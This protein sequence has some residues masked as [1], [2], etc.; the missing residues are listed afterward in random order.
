MKW[1]D[2]E[3]GEFGWLD[4]RAGIPTS[5][6]FH[7]ILTPSTRKLSSQADR[8]LYEC[9]S[10]RILGHPLD[11]AQIDGM[12]FVERGKVLEKEA[13]PAYE[14]LN[15][16]T[17]KRDGYGFCTTDDGRVGCSPD[18]VIG[19]DGLTEIKCR[20]FHIHLAHLMGSTLP[21]DM[22]QVQGAL[23]VCEREWCDVYLHNPAM[24]RVQIRVY[25]D[26]DYIRD[27]SKAVTTFAEGLERAWERYQAIDP[28]GRVEVLY[29][30]A[31]LSESEVEAV[32]VETRA[33][34]S[35]GRIEPEERD[36]IVQLC[37]TGDWREV[38]TRM[39]ALKAVAVA[40]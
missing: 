29:S 24:S 18:G 26:E 21:A 7:R 6:Q 13:I 39:A 33:A 23:W 15:D 4:A 25:R 32:E 38:R 27:I 30:A 28:A 19:D 35:D 31:E 17:V 1:H 9:L 2:L 16:A 36:E 22:T 14:F 40:A 20:S 11:F 8:Y 10:E 37:V 34:V 3:Q 12:G 5:S